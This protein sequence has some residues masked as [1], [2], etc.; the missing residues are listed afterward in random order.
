MKT[1]LPIGVQRYITELREI[2]RANLGVDSSVGD[3]Y[4]DEDGLS[5]EV[6]HAIYFEVVPGVGARLE[7]SFYINPTKPLAEQIARIRRQIIAIR[8]RHPSSKAAARIGGEKG[9]ARE[10]LKALYRQGVERCLD[11]IT[12]AD[13]GIE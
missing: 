13:L 2:V 11:T 10:S 8:E 5:V 12:D 1:D 6:K 3:Y 7:S 9:L 4:H